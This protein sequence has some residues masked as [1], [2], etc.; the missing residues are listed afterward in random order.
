MRSS[1]VGEGASSWAGGR[2][3][4]IGPA[5]SSEPT[6]FARPGDFAETGALVEPKSSADLGDSVEMTGFPRSGTFAGPGDFV[7]RVL[8]ADPWVL[9]GLGRAKEVGGAKRC[10]IRPRRTPGVGCDACVSRDREKLRARP[11][12]ADGAFD[13]GRAESSSKGDE[14]GF[15]SSAGMGELHIGDREPGA[16]Q[17]GRARAEGDGGQAEIRAAQRRARGDLRDRRRP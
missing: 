3:T 13:R 14:G 10:A 7:A 6:A 11:E 8:I 16:G 1:G 12:Q 4:T 17:H 5:S 2:P 15:S 9:S